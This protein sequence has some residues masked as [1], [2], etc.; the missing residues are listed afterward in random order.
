[1]EY[2]DGTTLRTYL[3]D[4]G[5]LPLDSFHDLAN[6][7]LEGMAA[8]H[9]QGIIHRDIKPENLMVTP[10]GQVKFLDFGIARRR[11][12]GMEA[13]TTTTVGDSRAGTIAGT[14]QYMAPESLLGQP[15]DERADVFAL[16]AVFYEMLTGR[17]PFE[18]ETFAAVVD[19]VL[20]SHPDA[21]ETLNPAAGAGLSAVV[22]RMLAKDPAA[23]F[24]SAAEVRAELA[25]PSGV[26][27]PVRAAVRPAVAPRLV[28]PSSRW[29]RPALA[30]AG[31]LLIVA[32]ATAWRTLAAPAL[33][34]NRNVAVLAPRATP[35]EFVPF[36]LGSAEF[37]STRL[38]RHSGTPGL[39]V[40]S[41]SRGLSED[42]RSA[43]DAR[44][45]LGA[46]LALI[47]TFEQLPDAFRGRLDLVE[48][49]TGR[50]LATRRLEAPATRPFAFL[51]Q[52]YR[53]AAAMLGLRARHTDA[54]AESGIHG[55]G[56]LR[57]HFQGLG[58]MR[59][60]RTPEEARSA[61][62]DFETA[63]RTEP[64]AAAPRAGLAAAQFA[65]NTLVKDSTLVTLAEATAREALAL[66][67]TRVE[68]HRCLATIL[69]S[70]R[71]DAEALRE[72]AR[73]V[74]LDSTDADAYY[75]MGRMHARLG[76][77]QEEKALYLAAVARRP[78]GWQPWSWLAVWN[79][80]NGQ[81][82]EAT[83][84]YRQMIRCAPDY[85]EGY[86]NLG[87]LLVLRGRYAAA[88]D[89]LKRALALRPSKGAFDNLG[90]AY[91]NSGR[92]QEAI[93]AYNQ[94]F[95]FGTADYLSWLNLG[96]AY[97]WLRNR[98]D[99]AAGAYAQAIRLGREEM[100]SRLRAGRTPDAS[101]PAHLAPVFARLE[102]ADSARVY[103]RRALSADSANS[104]V[105]FHAALTYWQLGE[106]AKA[107]AW[108]E[109]SVRAGYP[110]QWL[111]DSPMFQ[112]WRADSAFRAL[113]KETSE[114]PPAASRS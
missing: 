68:A 21:V 71:K 103:L 17:R 53:A 112:E 83:R 114:T 9:A 44:K 94:A 92:L 76:R 11:A 90:T 56:T 18:G 70:Q 8:A 1:M 93:D 23:R 51:D 106:H 54:A 59:T 49:A 15:V 85:A 91:F 45:I 5:P 16:G 20:N 88:V 104:A 87:G 98:K 111:H 10:G 4:R 97:Y 81:M 99:Q 2:V 109:R 102:Q 64:D 52:T 95:Q 67:S 55:T 58:R 13:T 61:I 75:A 66:D 39:Q 77:L 35:A 27:S 78:D 25:T 29:R 40:A 69:S 50:V 43:A 7:C 60:A 100:L 12:G 26:G 47:P 62:A 105:Q 24:A 34:R 96:D 46:N 79:Y 72:Y 82:D 31:V 38:R 19:R 73:T 14:P 63:C 108:L 101:I 37:L 89:T 36:A 33:P 42:V 22:D 57:F 6:Q 30:G 80:R 107:M 113:V 41:F 86:A 110:T 48:C 28:R 84:A 74:Q 3:N 32:A 65:A